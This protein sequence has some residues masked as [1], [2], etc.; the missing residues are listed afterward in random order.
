M[1]FRSC[2]RGI[3][4]KIIM[5]ETC[6]SYSEKRC[7]HSLNILLIAE[8]LNQRTLWA[9]CIQKYKKA[10]SPSYLLQQN[11]SLARKVFFFLL[12]LFFFFLSF[13]FFSFFL[14]VSSLKV[15]L[16]CVISSWVI[17]LK[18]ADQGCLLERTAWQK[19]VV[20]V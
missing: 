15:A 16:D 1:T 5:Y 2:L 3:S 20:R 11:V 17:M 13:F 14:S 8:Q 10:A 19:L 7:P 18:H 6:L 4:I 12:V 9:V